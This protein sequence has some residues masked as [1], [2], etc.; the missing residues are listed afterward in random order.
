MSHFDEF[1][2]ITKMTQGEFI[3]ILESIPG[4]K[5]LVVHECL[6]RPLDKIA[7][8]SFLHEHDCLRVQRLHLDKS[9]YWSREI[10]HRVFLVRPTIAVARKVSIDFSTIGLV[11]WIFRFV[12]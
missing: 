2:L 8:M 7:S 4:N 6:M 1:G 3:H 9:I 11:Y 5:E 12:N 10:D